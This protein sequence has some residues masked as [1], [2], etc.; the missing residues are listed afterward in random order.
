MQ[1]TRALTH[2]LNA[3]HWTD[4]KLKRYNIPFIAPCWSSYGCLLTSFREGIYELAAAHTIM[5]VL[6]SR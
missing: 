6:D 5:A 3:W 4:G 2:G 1:R